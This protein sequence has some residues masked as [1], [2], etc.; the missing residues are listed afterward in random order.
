[1]QLAELEVTNVL[2]FEH[3]R[4]EFATPGLTLLVGPNNAGKSAFLSVIERVTR[5]GTDVDIGRHGTESGTVIATFRLTDPERAELLA[6]EE[7]PQPAHW[8]ETPALEL[9]RWEFEIRGRDRTL[10]AV[11]IQGGDG[12]MHAMAEKSTWGQVDASVFRLKGWFQGGPRTPPTARNKHN[13][14]N[15]DG[16]EDGRVGDLDWFATRL[17]DWSAGFFHFMP[18]RPG[19][20]ATQGI[21]SVTPDLAADGANLAEALSFIRT[22]E[23]E[24]WDRLNAVINDLVPEV[25]TLLVPVAGTEVSVVFLNPASGHRTNLKRVGTGVEQLLMAAYVGVCRPSAPILVLEEPETGIHPD[26]QRALL[27]YLRDW[28][29]DR[30]IV[31][32]TH[33][34]VFLDRE[35]AKAPIWV[36]SRAGGTSQV[37][38]TT[39]N[40]EILELLGLRPSDVLSAAGLLIV[41]GESD[42]GCMEGWFG[43][44]LRSSHVRVLPAGGGDFAWRTDMF[45]DWLAAAT[46]L[47]PKVIFIRDRDEMDTRAVSKIT[48]S[49]SVYVLSR[50]EMENFLLDARVLSDYIGSRLDE[51]AAEL[52][53]VAAVEAALRAMADT[54]L[55]TV[56][57]KRV[58]FKLGAYRPLSRDVVEKLQ[59][60]P[61]D[62]GKVKAVLADH[63]RELDRVDKLWEAEEKAVR[64][65]WDRHWMDWVDGSDLL[66]GLFARAGVGFTKTVDTPALASLIAPPV[67]LQSAVEALASR[68][69]TGDR[70][71]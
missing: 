68:V 2:A 14:Q 30:Q 8:L 45:S 48:K 43:P 17:S 50:R 53:D 52:W 29:Q 41:E 6:K 66:A 71:N 27:S 32:S 64:N 13:F 24:L 46:S 38:P 57:L 56:V 19:A 39:S 61:L 58:A 35:G 15:K 47:G 63:V 3:A 4:V 55:L 25:G 51:A 34:T 26:A 62:L 70:A 11:R 33:S 69:L 5:R 9:V 23:P 10:M 42:A 28:S 60:K 20:R 7:A 44:L 65:G 1:M 21:S 22:N 59:R 54:H 16:L 31:C 12:A 40:P 49:G 36:V 18:I 67:E 37:R